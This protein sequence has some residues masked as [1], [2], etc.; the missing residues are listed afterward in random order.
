MIYS[1]IY[2]KEEEENIN[3]VNNHN[4]VCHH[5]TVS[6]GLH[7]VGSGKEWSIFGW[8]YPGDEEDRCSTVRHLIVTEEILFLE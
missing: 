2:R 4:I 1:L 5:D 8:N 6:P 3:E 7:M